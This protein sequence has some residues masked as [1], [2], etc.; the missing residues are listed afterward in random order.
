MAAS[1]LQNEPIKNPALKGILN[2]LLLNETMFEEGNEFVYETHCWLCWVLLPQFSS[3]RKYSIKQERRKHLSI[4]VKQPSVNVSND[5]ARLLPE[6]CLVFLIINP[7]ELPRS[8][9]HPNSFQKVGILMWAYYIF[10][11]DYF[12]RLEFFRVWTGLYFGHFTEPTTTGAKPDQ[13]T[14]NNLF[15]TETWPFHAHF[16]KLHY[17]VDLPRN[18]TQKIGPTNCIPES[19]NYIVW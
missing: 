4:P 2:V 15:S 17:Q 3:K 11:S 5:M 8:N 1:F 12:F 16:W 7:P 18:R 10:L 6:F 9:L 19:E 13:N 14:N